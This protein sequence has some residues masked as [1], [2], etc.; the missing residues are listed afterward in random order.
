MFMRV[1]RRLGTEI[2]DGDWKQKTTRQTGGKEHQ[3]DLLIDLIKIKSLCKTSMNHAGNTTF[4][5]Y[6]LIS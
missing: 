6:F 5:V 3:R 4:I 2:G 1:G